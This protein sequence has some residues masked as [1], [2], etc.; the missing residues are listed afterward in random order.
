MV[1]AVGGVGPSDMETWWQ[2]GARGFG[3]GSEVYKVGQS[4]EETR[5]KAAKVVKVISLLMH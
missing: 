4:L 2:A 1:L 3:L 5:E